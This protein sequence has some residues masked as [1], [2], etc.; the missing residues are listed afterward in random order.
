MKWQTTKATVVPTARALSLPG[1]AGCSSVAAAAV[2]ESK[3]KKQFKKIKERDL[4]PNFGWKGHKKG[5]L[6]KEKN[7]FSS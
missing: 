7:K 2:C 6:I 3:K 4:G 5:H 1:F